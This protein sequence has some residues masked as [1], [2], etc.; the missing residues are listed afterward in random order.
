MGEGVAVWVSGQYG[1]KPLVEWKSRGFGADVSLSDLLGKAFRSMPEQD[2]YP[3]AGLFFG[4]LVSRFGVDAVRDHLYG[5]S[6]DIWAKACE[7]IGSDPS[8]VERLFDD[9]VAGR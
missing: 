2:V 4:G 3:L 9:I 1:G 6:P 5:A 8:E 7:S